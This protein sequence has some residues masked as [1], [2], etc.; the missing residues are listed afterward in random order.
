MADYNSDRTG[1]NIDATL[2]KVDALDAKIQPTG[3]GVNVDG[4][5]LADEVLVNGVYDLKL[6]SGLSEL[7]ADDNHSH[8]FTTAGDADGF[9]SRFGALGISSRNI[10]TGSSDIGL[11]AGKQLRLLIDHTGDVSFYEDTGTTAKMV[12]D[13]SAESLG[14]GTTA[15]KV[16]TTGSVLEIESNLD[17]SEL[18]LGNSKGG[19]V[20][21]EY[22][23]GLIFKNSDGSGTAP[24]YSGIKA[25][26][27][28]TFGSANLE[29]YTGR[30]NYENGT[31]SVMRLL[32]GTAASDNV[33][34]FNSNV[35]IGGAPSEK[36]HVSGDDAILRLETTSTTGN[37]GVEFW[38]AQGGASLSGYIGYGDSSNL[39][40]IQGNGNG[41]VFRK[42]SNTFPSD[43][44]MRLDSSGNLLVGT[45]SGFP[46]STANIAGVHIGGATNGRGYF[47]NDGGRALNLNRMGSDGD[48]IEFR[49]DAV[50]V[51]EIGTAAGALYITGDNASGNAAGLKFID[52]SS[53][54]IV[55]ATS[56][57]ADADNLIDLGQSGAR[58][59]D[60]YLAGG[61]KTAGS[62][63]TPTLVEDNGG[64]MLKYLV[65][66]TLNS[67]QKTRF[68]FNIGGRRSVLVKIKV[69]GSYT[70]SNTGSNH[71]AGEYTV[72]LF[73]KLSW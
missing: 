31:E 73:F 25:V 56:G 60:L 16:L 21:G 48:I 1:A 39:F 61:V 30:E 43:E 36:L 27:S 54:R 52:G 51:G 26:A 67:G 8:I 2:D 12:W 11:F 57:G 20:G 3:T 13:A 18:I 15:T 41:T 19:T 70:A 34:V 46:G 33:A 63:T 68:T 6:R 32:G 17:G 5:V 55:P 22:L 9:F 69:A 44:A 42:G 28:D 38:D 45:T 14:I 40:T 65:T 59:K 23:G 29:F 53:E 58:F 37:A 64:I 71:V 49:K 47:S 7:P 10:N 62:S 66:D 50:P 35:G 4:R 72:R 24:H